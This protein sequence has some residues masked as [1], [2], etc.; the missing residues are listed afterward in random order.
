MITGERFRATVVAVGLAMAS[1][2]LPAHAQE[3]AP[4][5]GAPADAPRSRLT[6]RGMYS[7]ETFA[8][9]NFHLG[10]GGQVES[11]GA[12]EADNFWSQNLLLLPRFI[13]TDDLN[14]NV[15]MDVGQGVWGF[16]GTVESAPSEPRSFYSTS[17]ALTAVDIDW[18]YLAYRHRGT[19]T[20]WYLGLQE[21]ALGNRLV[22]DHDAPGVQ[23]YKTLDSFGGTLELGYAKESE[24]GSISDENL[25]NRAD[26]RSGPDRRDADLYYV[27][28]ESTSPRFAVNPFFAWYQDRSNADGT[29]LS[30]DGLPYLDARFRPNVTRA[31]ALGLAVAGRIGGLQV[32]F[33]YDR[34]SGADR[35]PNEDS[36][37]FEQ[38]DVNNGDLTGSNLYLRGSLTFSAFDIG[39]IYAQGSG[40]ADPFAGEGNINRLRTDGRFFITE[41]WDDALMPDQGIHPDGMGSPDVRGYRELENTKIMQGFLA[42]RPRHN[43][44]VFAS[45]S[46]IRASEPIQAWADAD[47]NA[48]IQP[49][50]MTGLISDQLGSEFDVRID[51]SLEQKV[52]VSLRGGLFLPREAASLLLYGTNRHQESAR[53][54]RL[55]VAVPIPEFSLGG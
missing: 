37:A 54:L 15:K 1:G 18:A 33:E 19:G 55:T 31:T 38:H 21:F 14:V 42:V 46:L 27:A 24:S 28:W 7:V 3:G 26:V 50:E 13:L 30:P 8:Q 5:G 44:H 36:G 17:D 34:L 35:V 23:M 20:R 43:L 52:T 32:D 9:K 53:E 29:T 16:D 6:L 48:V 45:A 11:G 51:W 49:E 22:L 10:N 40:D 41:V 39:G 47:S 4:S 12:T 25:T 2:T